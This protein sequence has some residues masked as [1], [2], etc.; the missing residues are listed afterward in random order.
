MTTPEDE[1]EVRVATAEVGILTLINSKLKKILGVL[2]KQIPEGVPV[3]FPDITVTGTTLKHFIKDHPYRPLFNLEV[4]NAGPD[5]LY[6]KVNDT[7][8]VKIKNRRAQTF[9]FKRAGIRQAQLRVDSGDS[10][11]GELTGLY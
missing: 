7:H 4:Y 2:E 6:V 8:E 5:N 10:A 1:E 9:D 3:D 11:T